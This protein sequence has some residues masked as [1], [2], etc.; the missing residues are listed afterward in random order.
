M[1]RKK[2]ILV[3][4]VFLSVF[5]ISAQ[6]SIVLP[7][8]VIDEEDAATDEQNLVRAKQEYLKNP[9]ENSFTIGFSYFRNFN[10][11]YF[12]RLEGVNALGLQFSW[13]SGRKLGVYF[14][15]SIGFILAP[16][17]TLTEGNITLKGGSSEKVFL[18]IG[19]NLLGTTSTVFLGLGGYPH[20][21]NVLR[22]FLAGGAFINMVNY[23]PIYFTTK[24]NLRH[25][26]LGIGPALEFRFQFRLNQIV[27]ID[28]GSLVG[29]SYEPI[30]WS[31]GVLGSMHDLVLVP[32]VSAV[33]SWK[34]SAKQVQL[35][36]W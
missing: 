33:F 3:F 21:G 13:F 36:A 34:D 11:S 32:T 25:F 30:T 26:S 28:F 16:I 4:I 7:Q 22:I 1:N 6:E 17:K 19:K 27:S 5:R 20:S 24:A 23:M 12:P 9:W 14:E 8:L 35:Y 18:D 2:C 31:K 29:Y 10:I 15:T